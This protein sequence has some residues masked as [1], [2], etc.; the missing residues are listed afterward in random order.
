MERLCGKPND[1]YKKCQATKGDAE[2]CKPQRAAVD[3]CNAHANAM[4][5]KINS[6]CYSQIAS[7]VACAGYGHVQTESDSSEDCR[8]VVQE[9]GKCQEEAVAEFQQETDAS[10]DSA[11]ASSGGARRRRLAALG[12]LGSLGPLQLSG[13][14]ADMSL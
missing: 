2:A 13:G 10:L 6:M 11:S 3:A 4:F 1:A 12:S 8:K 7:Y 14:G 5:D 9:L